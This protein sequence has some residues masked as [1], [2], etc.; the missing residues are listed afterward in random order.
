MFHACF[1]QNSFL[2]SRLHIKRLFFLGNVH[3]TNHI[4]QATHQVRQPSWS[5]RHPNITAR[6]TQLLQHKPQR[7]LHRLANSV[8]FSIQKEMSLLLAV[9]EQRLV[10]D[11]FAIGIAL[12]L[13]QRNSTHATTYIHI[14]GTGSVG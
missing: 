5:S 9:R 3:H 2:N 10:C 1:I 4:P 6:D 12:E 7:K 13:S 8:F 14:T 11:G